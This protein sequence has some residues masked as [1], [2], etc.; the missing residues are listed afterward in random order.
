MDSKYIGL[1]RR[2]YIHGDLD[3]NTPNIV[4]EEIAL[5]RG[6]ENLEGLSNQNKRAQVIDAL[7]KLKPE[8]IEN[9]QIEEMSDKDKLALKRFINPNMDLKWTAES[10]TKALLFILR[11]KDQENFRNMDPNFIKGVQTPESTTNLN[12]TIIYSALRLRGVKLNFST[13]FDQMVSL[14]R[15]YLRSD[16]A[17][18]TETLIDYLST[19]TFSRAVILNTLIS[20]GDVVV[21]DFFE[22]V[23][24]GPK[25]TTSRDGIKSKNHLIPAK[26]YNNSQNGIEK[27]FKNGPSSHHD[28]LDNLDPSNIYS[29][30]SKSPMSNGVSNG[31]FG[32]HETLVKKKLI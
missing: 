17:S 25:A 26:T 24:S 11:F 9:T 21:E 31:N 10:L 5:C 3:N 4:L 13:T 32:S 28:Q 19:S 20:M 27:H 15:I 14:L 23:G 7:N 1:S 16:R 12:A 18:L 2:D 8:S 30:P 22:L 29:I 6:Y